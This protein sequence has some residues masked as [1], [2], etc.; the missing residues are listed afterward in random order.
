[1]R[2]NM[3]NTSLEH[4]ALIRE[5][6]PWLAD[7]LERKHA[8]AKN[9]LNVIVTKSATLSDG[10]SRLEVGNRVVADYWGI[11]ERPDC[12][13]RAGTSAAKAALA[14]LSRKRNAEKPARKPYKRMTHLE[15]QAALDAIDSAPLKGELPQPSWALPMSRNVLTQTG[16]DAEY[17]TGTSPFK[18]TLSS[19]ARE[20]ILAD[21]EAYPEH[22]RGAGLCGIIDWQGV[23]IVEANRTSPSARCGSVQLQMDFASDFVWARRVQESQGNQLR[24]LGTFHSHPS[25]SLKPSEADIRLWSTLLASVDRSIAPAKEIGVNLIVGYSSE[26]WRPALAA[27]VIRRSDGFRNPLICERAEITR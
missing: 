6:M 7:E 1:M 10:Y 2:N 4:R 9:A 20:V 12:F 15:R 23:R 19:W 13:A 14:E 17:C 18:V 11:R 8:R 26:R 21:T 22:E 25:G 24:Y 27:Y 5:R 3:P 16:E